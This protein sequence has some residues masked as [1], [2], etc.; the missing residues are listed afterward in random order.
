M[1]ADMGT[2][3]P[4]ALEAMQ[5]VAR[6]FLE[7]ALVYGSFR[8]WLAMTPDGAVLGGGAVLIHGRPPSPQYLDP[9]H[10]EILNVYTYPEH[11]RRGV[12]RRLMRTMIEWCRG[13][14]FAAVTLRASPDGRALYEQLGFT[15]TN[16]MRL[17][18]R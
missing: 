15:P 7:H 8:E 17:E 3:D 4:A 2:E 14:G 5:K 18:L 10:A 6:P 11:R 9:R 12:A 16:E 1:F 13:E